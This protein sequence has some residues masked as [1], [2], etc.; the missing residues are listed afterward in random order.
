[1]HVDLD[2]LA[3]EADVHKQRAFGLEQ[4]AARDRNDAKLAKLV[5]GVPAR[6]L[7]EG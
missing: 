2:K 6:W 4:S 5:R 3:S 1:L 7:G